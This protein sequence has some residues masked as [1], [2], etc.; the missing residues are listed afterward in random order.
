MKTFLISTA[1][2]AVMST[3]ALAQTADGQVP[4]AKFITEWDLDGDGI[5]TVEEAASRRENI[6][7]TFD[8]DS[9]G[10]LDAAEYAFFDDARANAHA[11]EE[12]GGMGGERKAARG[13]T[14]AFNDVDGD[15]SVTLEE[16]VSKSADWIALID[17]NGDGVVTTDDFGP[18]G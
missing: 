5:V 8:E 1:V 3:T 15:G 9:N 2:I 12:N 18:Q 14:L 17:R 16:F 11:G 4:G 13:F 7:A 10:T 6:F